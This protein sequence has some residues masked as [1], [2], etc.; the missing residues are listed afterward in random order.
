MSLPTAIPGVSVEWSLCFLRLLRRGREPT[1][2]AYFAPLPFNG[3]G[4]PFPLL[5]ALRAAICL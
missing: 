4:R 5:V 1:C 2:E 3:G